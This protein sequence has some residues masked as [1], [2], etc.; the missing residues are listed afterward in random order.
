MDNDNDDDDDDD[1]EDDV[2]DDDDDDDATS[3]LLKCDNKSIEAREGTT[4]SRSKG[5]SSSITALESAFN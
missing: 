2:V 5:R 4:G 3:V 1:D